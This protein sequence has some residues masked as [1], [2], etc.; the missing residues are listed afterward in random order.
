MHKTNDPGEFRTHDLRIKRS[1][2]DAPAYAATEGEGRDAG[3]LKA[4]V[5]GGAP[6]GSDAGASETRHAHP[7]PEAPAADPL[8]TP[9]GCRRPYSGCD[10][11]R[12]GCAPSPALRPSAP[13]E[14]AGAAPAQA[15]GVVLTA[16]Q[17][18]EIEARVS[19][20][21]PG[22]WV[23]GD[24][25]PERHH[26]GPETVL[27]VLPPERALFG[28]HMVLARL[29][30]CKG[31]GAADAA[32]IAHARA[33]IPA[34]LATLRAQAARVAALEQEV[35][36]QAA[37]LA[38]QDAENAQLRAVLENY[39]E[40][41]AAARRDLAQ[42]DVTRDEAIEEA[43]AARAAAERQGRVMDAV[44]AIVDQPPGLMS[45]SEW[46]RQSVLRTTGFVPAGE[47]ADLLDALTR[48]AA[49]VPPRAGE[50]GK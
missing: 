10:W 43:R 49:P 48:A 31:T 47:L 30:N 44:N 20:T 32:F 5:S 46:L 15:D 19:A 34:L 24:H 38:E 25:T 2:P 9:D 23:V 39:T 29:N 26:E 8:P 1:A 37:A 21:T 4:A 45:W 36:V 28:T 35:T 16:A 22:E 3:A 12:C 7:A 18:A 42:G 50:G 6:C 27:L 14:G 11:P 33:D 41:L 40:R 17:I 13:P